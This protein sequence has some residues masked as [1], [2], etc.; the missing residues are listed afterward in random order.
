MSTACVNEPTDRG[1]AYSTFGLDPVLRQRRRRPQPAQRR[2]PTRPPTR[3]PRQQ[4][5]AAA[6]D[7]AWGT[8]VDGFGLA[9]M[10]QIFS[11]DNP[12]WPAPP[13]LTWWNTTLTDSAHHAGG[14]YS[15]IARAS[16]ADADRRLGAFLDLLDARGLLDETAFL[17]TADHGS[18]G[19]DPSLHRGLGRGAAR[20]R[21][22]L[23][24]R[25]L[26]LDLPRRRLTRLTASSARRRGVSR[27]GVS[28]R[29]VRRRVDHGRGLARRASAA[30]RAAAAPAG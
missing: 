12:Q 22:R 28:S 30:P 16:L 5:V 26:R 24:R 1:A 11:G 21:H 8:Q 25:G 18:E 9:Q 27:S 23:P 10:Q 7:Y 15:A 4:H 6:D 17:L 19:A 14:P 20:G 13:R 2:C 29:V 3:T